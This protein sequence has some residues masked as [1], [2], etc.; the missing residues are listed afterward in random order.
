MGIL[1]DDDIVTGLACSIGDWFTAK[2]IGDCSFRDGD[3]ERTSTQ[4]VAGYGR[5]VC[6]VM[7]DLNVRKL[8]NQ[9]LF[10]SLL[11]LL[12]IYKLTWWLVR[13]SFNAKSR[14]EYLWIEIGH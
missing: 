14:V 9:T 4:L 3:M 7:D 12:H 1:V 13:L 5:W 8:F 11:N 6:T 10:A 2:R